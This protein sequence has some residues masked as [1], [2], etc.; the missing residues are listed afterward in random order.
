MTE[1][2]PIL[3]IGMPVYN[4]ARYIEAA[5]DSLLAQTWDDFELIISDN[6]ST[7]DTETICRRY[8][9]LDARV[10]YHREAENRGA[11]WNFNHV[12]SLARGKFFKWASHDDVCSPEFLAACMDA[13]RSDKNIVCCH[14][15]TGNIDASGRKLPDL[16][17]PTD[18]GEVRRPGKRRRD[19]SSHTLHLRFHD[20]LIVTG[21]GVRLWGMYRVDALRKTGLMRDFYGSEK[22]LM[23]E[24]SALG[25][26]HDVPEVLF[27]RRVHDAAG[28]AQLSTDSQRKFSN[29]NQRRQ[30]PLLRKLGGYMA[31]PFHYP[32][33]WG[34]RFACYFWIL[35][36]VFQVRKWSGVVA[37]WLFG[38]GLH[39]PG[40][41]PR[42]S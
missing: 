22:L 8:A 15:Y 32:M 14:S 23:A 1:S 20:V 5:L 19:G 40:Q 41:A 27:W 36:Y 17:D 39:S 30:Y 10:S 11:Y 3:S 42:R 24:L 35:R 4:G 38:R 26:I 6:A 12:F 28:S 37:N 25:R 13:L 34:D 18:A 31:I 2:P 29:P 7:D 33:S 9:E 16:P 21:W